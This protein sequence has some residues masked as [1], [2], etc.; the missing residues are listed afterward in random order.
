[1]LFRITCNRCGRI[2]KVRNPYHLI[3]ACGKS[4]FW[5]G[6]KGNC[7]VYEYT[8]RKKKRPELEL[9]SEMST[10]EKSEFFREKYPVEAIA[11]NTT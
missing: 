11:L 9:K 4:L 10:N 8:P 1:M 7:E 6:E 5:F 2:S 3:C